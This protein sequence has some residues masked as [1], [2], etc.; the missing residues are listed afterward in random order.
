MEC[1]GYVWVYLANPEGR[2]VDQSAIPPAPELPKFS[3]RFRIAHLTADLN[4]SMDTAI[5]GLMDPAHGPFVHQSWWWRSR[6]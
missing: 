3:A 2:T 1:D 6:R 4:C 5:V